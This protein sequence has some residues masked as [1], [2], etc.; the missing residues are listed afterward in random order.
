FSLPL[1]RRRATCFSLIVFSPQG[2]A[3]I[4][5]T[6]LCRGATCFP[7]YAAGHGTWNAPKCP[8]CFGLPAPLQPVAAGPAANRS[9]PH[10]SIH[11]FVRRFAGGALA[12][13]GNHIGARPA[14]GCCLRGLGR[15]VRC[16]IFGWLRPATLGQR[17]CSPWGMMIGGL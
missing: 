3:Y 16:G 1:P 6:A 11:P 8:R 2:A 7:L 10:T 14:A 4:F 12:S 13:Q 15:G 9:H 17:T 5:L